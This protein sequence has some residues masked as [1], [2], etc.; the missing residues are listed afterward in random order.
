M[1]R[2]YSPLRY[3]G[4][5]NQFYNKVMHLV[6]QN[7]L[8]HRTYVEPFA[9]GS[10]VALKLLLEDVMQ[11]IVINDYD[12]SI[13]AFW[14]TLL[15]FPEWLSNKIENT[16]VSM[17]QYYIQREIQ[18]NKKDADIRELGFSTLFLN[19]VNRSGIINAGPIGGYDQQGNYK[20][21]CRFNKETLIQK[22][23]LIASQKDRIELY[24]MDAVE[25]LKLA[26]WKQENEELFLFLDPP[27]YK[28]GNKLYVNFYSYDDHLNLANLVK[29]E[30][31]NMQWIITYDIC[32]EIKSIYNDVP[33]IEVGLKYSVQEKRS[34]SEYLF[35]NQLIVQGIE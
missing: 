4:G 9:G 15:H 25:F 35:Y 26:R 17:E 16:P 33:C 19:R 32:E 21:D 29:Q 13:Y 18:D 5:K 7:N 24:N 1:S 31:A 11:K 23:R 10:G 14:Y 6:E 12:L 28:K 22:I 34:A 3:P 8:K 20:L 2:N 30:L 27:Y